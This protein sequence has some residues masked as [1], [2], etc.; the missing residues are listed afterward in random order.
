MKPDL[1]GFASGLAGFI[2]VICV[3]GSNFT[4]VTQPVA[5]SAFAAVILMRFSHLG[6]LAKALLIL[7]CLTVIGSLA[8]GQPI[9]TNLSSTLFVFGFILAAGSL[10]SLASRD[11]FLR[12]FAL[13]LFTKGRI[14]RFLALSLGT[15]MLAL[16]LLVGAVQFSAGVIASQEAVSTKLRVD[17]A[18]AILAGFVVNPIV[19]PVAIP[20]VVVSS[21]WQSFNWSSSA[22]WLFLAGVLIWACG[23][24]SSAMT[25]SE[26]TPTT[27]RPQS[28]SAS[29]R[30]PLG[31]VTF[32]ASLIAVICVA[33][34]A[35]VSLTLFAL[36][37]IVLLSFFWPIARKWTTRS[38]LEGYA[39][40][41]NEATV[42]G[43]SVALG[44]LYA[45]LLP[46]EYILQLAS[47]IFSFGPLLPGIVILAFVV[48]GN[49]GLQPPVCFL[50]ML[51]GL[52]GYTE[53]TE[54]SPVLFASVI[55]GWALNSVVAP[56]SV[57]V[58]IASKAASVSPF[59]FAW[60]H[61]VSFLLISTVSVSILLSIVGYK[62]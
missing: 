4:P 56:F 52:Q 2:G 41:I 8:L 31:L 28:V 50:L 3:L 35:G 47:V 42:V 59:Q 1:A 10:R 36:C 16:L 19:S 27:S 11:P 14:R 29:A 24:F 20:A 18:R 21:T 7:L 43:G 5:A 30:V 17:A 61:N 25:T 6:F 49:L 58:L 53:M 15:S 37:L 13:S 9:E 45:G 23:F 60:R 44:T 46:N 33:L 32:F 54:V 39:S 26:P 55:V 40:G 22:V 12:S 62:S 57:P 34:F 38:A 48:G 51:P